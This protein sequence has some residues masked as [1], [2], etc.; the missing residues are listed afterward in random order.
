MRSPA[1]PL[2]SLRFEDRSKRRKRQKLLIR[3]D[4]FHLLHSRAI[5]RIRPS[6][7][8]VCA[9]LTYVRAVREVAER[10]MNGRLGRRDRPEVLGLAP[11]VPSFWDTEIW[12][13]QGIGMKRREFITVLG[14]SAVWPLAAHAQLAKLPTIGFLGPLTQA[15]QS[16]GPRHLCSAC[17]S[18]VGSKIAQSRSSIAGQTD[19]ANVS[20][21]SP[22]SSSGCRSV[23]SSRGNRSGH[24][25]AEPATIL[26]KS[27]RLMLTTR[28]IPGRP[29]KPR[30]FGRCG[31][32]CSAIAV[33]L[34]KRLPRRS[35]RG[36]QG[37]ALPRRRR[38]RRHQRAVVEAE[39]IGGT[40][41]LT[42]HSILGTGRS[43]PRVSGGPPP[44]YRGPPQVGRGSCREREW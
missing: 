2:T 36:V 26:M 6:L 44:R 5:T 42:E 41:A 13:S 4:H 16:N 12:V 29:R 39:S 1:D 25:V 8:G 27:R 11:G 10:A 32:C 34:S 3:T 33:D 38:R 19:A 9:V 30:L 14:V 17:A 24:T 35:L 18:T 43:P 31:S 7:C 21:E 23:S 22:R 28:S 37:R 15:A 20:P 40:K